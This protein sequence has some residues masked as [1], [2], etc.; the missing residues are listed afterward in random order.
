MINNEPIKKKSVIVRYIINT[1]TYEIFEHHYKRCY[2]CH[3][4]KKLLFKR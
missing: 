4:E 3:E 1:V 2:I